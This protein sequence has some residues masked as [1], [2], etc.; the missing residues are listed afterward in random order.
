MN[1]LKKISIVLIVCMLT[2]L[3]SSVIK[4]VD[5]SADKNFN[6]F[7]EGY[8]AYVKPIKRNEIIW[9]Q[10]TVRLNDNND[11][12]KV[13]R[14]GV[15]MIELKY[16]ANA[17]NTTLEVNKHSDGTSYIIITGQHDTTGH[18]L[19]MMIETKNRYAY[20]YDV[21]SCVSE[22]VDLG[23]Y[24]QIY[25]GKTLVPLR[26]FIETFGGNVKHHKNGAFNIYWPSL[27]K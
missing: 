21:D 12:M 1:N 26:K 4:A 27:H 17:A 19:V 25:K 10:E 9:F 24:V 5:F 11:Y 16:L 20:V 18:T 7:V 23:G 14:N 8:N 13:V 2:F 22:V 15:S 3:N 6:A